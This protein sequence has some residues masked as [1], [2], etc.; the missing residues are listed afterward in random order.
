MFAERFD[1]FVL[2]ILL[3]VWQSSRLLFVVVVFLFGVFC[4]LTIFWFCHRAIH[5]LCYIVETATVEIVIAT[6]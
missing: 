1:V 3:I 4:I 2:L 6:L 5:I